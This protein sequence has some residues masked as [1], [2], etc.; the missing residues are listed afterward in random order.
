MAGRIATGGGHHSWSLVRDD[1]GHREY[2]LVHKVEMDSSLDGPALALQTPGIPLPGT[3]WVVDNDLDLWAYCRNDA[4]VTPVVEGEPNNYFLVEQLFSTKPLKRCGEYQFE[5]PLLEPMKV[6]GSFTK[7]LEE[8]HIDRF[9]NPIVNSAH[10]QVRGPKVEFDRNRPTVRIEQNVPFLQL[11]LLSHFMDTVNDDYLWGLPPRCVKL[12][13]VSWERLYYGFCY[14]YYRRVLDF[15]IN[16]ETF[17]RELLDEGTKV[18][19]GHWG[20]VPGTG[21]GTAT[22]PGWVLDNVG[23]ST[24]DP[25]NPQHFIRLTDRN[26][27][28]ISGPLNGAGLPAGVNYAVGVNYYIKTGA[29]PSPGAALSDTTNWIPLVGPTTPQEWQA[30]ADYVA[31]NL[32]YTANAGVNRYYVAV[33]ANVNNAPPVYPA[34]WLDLLSPPRSRGIWS[35]AASY[36]R[37]DFV[38][39]QIVGVTDIGTIKV[40]KYPEGNLLLL[41]I[42]LIL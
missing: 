36:V 40:E 28:L 17:D 24:P 3:L 8:A 7:F 13:N 6:S 11:D 22:T 20:D 26:G 1:E 33:S 34:V 18:L 14:A 10:E 42:P 32:V 5:D 19:N 16:F 2:K 30:G 21:T 15:D 27:N 31:G 9:G 25:N 38:R 37:G 35:N 41:G 4:T 23:G 39:T 29:A 12:S